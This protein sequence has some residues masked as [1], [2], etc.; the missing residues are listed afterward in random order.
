MQSCLIP[1]YS[2]W[3]TYARV[4]ILYDTWFSDTTPSLPFNYSQVKATSVIF[5]VTALSS[6]GITAA[7]NPNRTVSV[8]QHSLV[9]IVIIAVL[10]LIFN[11]TLKRT[12][13]PK[14]VINI[15]LVNFVIFCALASILLITSTNMITAFFALELLGA[16]TLYAFFVF[17]GYNISGSAQQSITATSSSVYQF[18][19][20]FFGSLFFYTALGILTYYHSSSTLQSSLARL[21]TGWPL[22]AQTSIMFA[23]LIKV[24]TG[25]WVFYKLS[26]YKGVTIQTIVVYTFVYFAAIMVFLF[27]VIHS[28]GFSTTQSF[29]LI[30]VIFLV[31]CSII[32]GANIFQTGS[33]M[34]FLSFSSLL[35]LTFII[36]QLA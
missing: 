11:S 22:W 32:F 16:V 14:N 29:G 21:A 6:C 30:S 28:S 10:F 35:N 1:V 34:L 12:H 18:I 20:N 33:I 31:S 26:I 27:E 3:V 4:K 13:A 2:Y 17:S 36:L 5:S 8:E 7:A 15:E 25:P 24:G 9:A 19:L 23:L